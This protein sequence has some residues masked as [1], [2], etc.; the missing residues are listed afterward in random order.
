MKKL[1]LFFLCILAA[2]CAAV[3]TYYVPVAVT[4]NPIGS[5]IGEGPVSEGIEAAALKAG[6]VKIA[7]I[8]IRY[9]ADGAYYIIS[10]E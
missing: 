2:G 9:S 10:G 4:D 3:Q 5:K 8:D 7:T 6:I 1:F